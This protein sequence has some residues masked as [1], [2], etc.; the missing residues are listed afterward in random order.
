[1]ANEIK[2]PITFK[3]PQCGHKETVLNTL[4]PKQ[5]EL[6]LIPEGEH[7]GTTRY[8]LLMAGEKQMN[9]I[10]LGASAGKKFVQIRYYRD[11]CLK[12]GTEYIYLVIVDEWV[13]PAIPKGPGPLIFPGDKIPGMTPKGYR[14]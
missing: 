6:G 2:S 4:A 3:C 11:I 9:E 8:K 10:R 14:K 12:C 5:I 7:V 1:M 13:V